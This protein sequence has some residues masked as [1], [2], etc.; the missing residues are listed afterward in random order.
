MNGTPA[1][2]GGFI[3]LDSPGRRDDA[4]GGGIHIEDAPAGTVSKLVDMSVACRYLAS[5]C[6]V[7]LKLDQW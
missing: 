1:S 4:Y 7:S 3:D 2:P 6:M 5:Q